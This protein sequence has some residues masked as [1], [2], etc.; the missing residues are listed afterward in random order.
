MGPKAVASDVVSRL[1]SADLMKAKSSNDTVIKKSTSG[2]KNKDG[3]SSSLA[4]IGILE[5]K[6]SKPSKSSSISIGRRKTSLTVDGVSSKAS[7]QSK[8]GMGGLT[9]DRVKKKS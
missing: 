3:A 7:T 1:Y 4:K 9:E 5:R 6:L 2:T 8:T